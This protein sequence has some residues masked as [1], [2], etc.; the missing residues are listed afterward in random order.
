MAK[1]LSLDQV[2][3]ASPCPMR[4]DDMSAVGDGWKVNVMFGT[5]GLSVTVRPAGGGVVL[6]TAQVHVPWAAEMLM[7]L[8]TSPAK[9]YTVNESVGFTTFE[10]GTST[11]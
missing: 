2:R 5:P 8:E 7:E 9:S 6:A 4:W 3:I 10:P 1:T 11:E